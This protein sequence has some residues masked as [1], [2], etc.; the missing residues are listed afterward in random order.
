[1]TETLRLTNLISGSTRIPPRLWY[2]PQSRTQASRM[3]LLRSPCARWHVRTASW[4]KLS[5]ESVVIVTSP[6]GASA[7]PIG[8]AADWFGDRISGVR[9]SRADVKCVMKVCAA[10]ILPFC[11]YLRNGQMSGAGEKGITHGMVPRSA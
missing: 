2:V 7:G 3:V 8:M 10:R 1:M 9:E 5:T 6:F 4:Q 11:R